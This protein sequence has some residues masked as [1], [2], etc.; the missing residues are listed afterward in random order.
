MEAPS[1]AEQAET[2][3]LRNALQ[4]EQAQNAT[5]QARLDHLLGRTHELEAQLGVSFVDR[6]IGR[7][8]RR[9]RETAERLTGAVGGFRTE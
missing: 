2:A 7:A 4:A 6:T 5:L 8:L 9:A 3:N 1:Q